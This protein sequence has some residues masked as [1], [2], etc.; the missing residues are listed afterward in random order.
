VV[1]RIHD[2]TWGSVADDVSPVVG[3]VAF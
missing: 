1:K 2:K 3:R